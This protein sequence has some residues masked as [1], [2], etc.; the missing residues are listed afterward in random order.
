M[1]CHKC[2]NKLKE[3]EKFCT[4]CGYYNSQDSTSLEEIN[5]QEDDNNFDQDYQSLLI[6]QNQEPQEK[7]IEIVEE[8]QEEVYEESYKK[9]NEAENNFFDYQEE[10]LLES[11]IGEDYK[12]VKKRPVNLYA[13]FLSW[14]YVLYRKM[15]ILGIIG[16]IG[17]YIFSIF[18]FDFLII[19]LV[20]SSIFLAFFFNKIYI[21][22]ASKK[23]KAISKKNEGVD[24]FTLENIIKKKGG[25]NF[26]T[27]LLIYFIFLLAIFFTKINFSFN[28]NYNTKFFNENS[29]NKAT[30]ISLIKTAYNDFLKTQKPGTIQEGACRVVNKKLENYKIYLKLTHN[31]TSVYLYY[32]TEKEYLKLKQSTDRINSLELKSSNQTIT[33]DEKRLLNDLKN[34]EEDYFNTISKSKEEDKLIA[35]KKNNSE[36][37]NFI[38]SKEE[39]TR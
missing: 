5:I 1:I 18:F 15:Y 23:V 8:P 16:L 4:I 26:I 22:I 21:F 31:N 12:V 25:V 14:M 3:N 34:V 19:Y 13:L 29:E 39:I 10:K 6:N 32:E 30:C 27:A 24:T 33:E 7:L 36:K 38:F 37:L 2:G 17:I 35:E 11:Y 9:V 20:L 28:K